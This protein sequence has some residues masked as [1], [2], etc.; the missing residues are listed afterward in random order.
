MMARAG[1]LSSEKKGRTVWYQADGPGLAARL[2]DLAEA[3]DELAPAADCCVDD[4][5]PC[6]DTERNT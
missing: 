3:V 4:D 5:C 6:G 1:L 2:R